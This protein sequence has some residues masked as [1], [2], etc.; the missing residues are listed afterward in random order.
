MSDFQ[1]A[2]RAIPPNDDMGEGWKIRYC[3]AHAAGPQLLAAC[4][5]ALAVLGIAAD[6]ICADPA[7]DVGVAASLEIVRR[8][9][10]EANAKAEGHP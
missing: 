4:Q 10:R 8:H 7:H 6:E 2:C 3:P 9:L 5:E 1:C